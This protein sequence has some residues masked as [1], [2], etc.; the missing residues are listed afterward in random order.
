MHLHSS[1]QNN[2]RTPR[3]QL[4]TPTEEAAVVQ[5]YILVNKALPAPELD[6]EQEPQQCSKCRRTQFDRSKQSRTSKPSD[7][8]AATT[9]ERKLNDCFDEEEIPF[10][11]LQV[12]FSLRHVT[13]V[14]WRSRP[15]PRFDSSVRFS[16]TA[17]ASGPWRFAPPAMVG[18]ETTLALT[19]NTTKNTRKPL[20]GS[21]SGASHT[22]PTKMHPPH[23]R[24]L[25]RKSLPPTLQGPKIT[26]LCKTGTYKA[27]RPPFSAE[28]S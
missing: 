4:Q 8:R 21:N 17:T 28:F 23:D 24:R 9:M 1:D 25:P 14:R 2:S 11:F 6:P 22:M 5:K 3:H 12:C 16:S 19:S 15:A 26:L 27:D 7:Q 13:N 10:V 18:P 20:T